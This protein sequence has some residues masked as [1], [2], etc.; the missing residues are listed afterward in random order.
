V[1]TTVTLTDIHNHLVPAVDDGAQSM[2]EALLHL[3]TLY[4][5][6]VSKLA[7]SPHLFGWLTDEAGALEQRLDRLEA[8]FTELEAACARRAGLPELFFGQEILCPTAAIAQR[9]FAEPRAGYRGTSYALVEFGFELPADVLSV[10]NAV[11]AAGRRIIISHPERYRR[12]RV[13]VHID[14]LRSW[15][16]AGA[17]LQVNAGSLLGDYGAGIE[18]LSWQ[19][20]KAGLADLVATDH[21]ADS[22]VVSPRAA[23]QKIVQLGRPD[24]AQLLFLENTTRVLTDRDLVAVPSL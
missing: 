2:Q 5:E 13:H 10:I 15:K 1:S 7:V 18:Q 19:L 21:H 12:N 24:I 3:G 6:G 16:Q 20:L 11:L 22:R 23:Y 14:E 4:Q 17:L 9:V 8:A